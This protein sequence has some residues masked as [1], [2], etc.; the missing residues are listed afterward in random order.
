MVCLA[1]LLSSTC[2]IT[3]KERKDAERGETSHAVCK[4]LLV[5]VLRNIDVYMVSTVVVQ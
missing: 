5:P 1:P 3:H 2:C 4:V